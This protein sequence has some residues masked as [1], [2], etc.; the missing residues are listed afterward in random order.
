[1]ARDGRTGGWMVKYSLVESQDYQ[2]SY[3]KFSYLPTLRINLVKT[4]YHHFSVFCKPLVAINEML[5]Q[6][7]CL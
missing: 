4:E 5:G 6:F 3:R 2:P 1:M 7:Q